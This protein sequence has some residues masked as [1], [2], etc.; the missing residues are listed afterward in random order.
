MV[1]INDPGLSSLHIHQKSSIAQNGKTQA[2]PLDK[3][4]LQPQARTPLIYCSILCQEGTLD[5]R[6]CDAYT[7]HFC[8]H[9][10]RNLCEEESLV[11]CQILLTLTFQKTYL[12]I[13][14]DT[15]F[16]LTKPDMVVNDDD[17][18]KPCDQSIDSNICAVVFLDTTCI[19]SNE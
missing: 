8:P 12:P 13:T 2:L 4:L 17:K 10:T 15:H 9:D 11:L 1:Q 19:N 14:K 3:E 18:Y 16:Q 6:A 5:L 7:V